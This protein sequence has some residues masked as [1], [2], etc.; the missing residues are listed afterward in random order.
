MIAER[1]HLES[2]RTWARSNNYRSLLQCGMAL[3]EQE[4]T[5]LEE[6]AR[7]ALFD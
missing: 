5:S 7:V 6:V 2:I 1:A 3:A 4:I